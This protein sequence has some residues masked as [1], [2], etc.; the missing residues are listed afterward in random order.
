MKRYP[1]LS[2]SE[3]SQ[4][5]LEIFN[6]I[7]ELFG[8]VPVYYRVLANVPTLVEANWLTHKKVMIT[9]VLPLQI[10]ELIFLAVARKRQ[11]KYCAS[12][13]LTICD[14][15]DVG[16]ENIKATLHDISQIKPERVAKLIELCITHIDD[17][18]GVQLA[19]YE[20]LMELG[21]SKRE[22]LEALYA[23][24]FADR[25]TFLTKILAM[26]IDQEV[27][28]YLVDNNLSIDK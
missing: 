9:G 10:K 11:C 16:E 5:T 23:T 13:H 7:D 6:E 8:L 14:M 2:D 18:D 27:I 17:P 1:I 22:I 28:K 4:E 21:V 20:H 24:G 3:V 26:D 25:S 12:I 15:F 19:E